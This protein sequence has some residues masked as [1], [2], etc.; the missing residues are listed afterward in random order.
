M[1]RMRSPSSAPCV[2]G[3]DG[4]IDSTATLRSAAR[5]FFTSAPMS[6]DLPEPGAP[7]T[8]T[9]LDRPVCGYTSRTSAQPAG[10]LFSTSEMAR[11]SARRSPSSRRWARLGSTATGRGSCQGSARLRSLP[12]ALGHVRQRAPG[13][14]AAGARAFRPEPVHRH[15][16]R[17]RAPARD[18]GH[19]EVAQ[20]AAH[21]GRRAADERERP[22][23]RAGRA[24]VAGGGAGR[25]RADRRRLGG[26]F[27][28]P[29]TN[30]VVFV[31]PGKAVLHVSKS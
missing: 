17:R 20:A 8:P 16:R 1:R 14:A 4:S 7:V 15:R 18:L 19:G 30:E 26:R 27:D 10:S 28:S 6:V 12:V 22:G 11:A 2:N 5:R 29:E 25:A 31:Q 9:T 3:E 13:R 23:Q 24:A 21:A